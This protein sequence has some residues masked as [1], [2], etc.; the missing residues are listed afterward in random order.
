M[1]GR[2]KAKKARID[3]VPYTPEP[4]GLRK[5][6]LRQPSDDREEA[7]VLGHGADAAPAVVDVLERIGVV[8]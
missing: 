3:V 1:P 4:G 2:L 6:R 7:I 5:V 8:S